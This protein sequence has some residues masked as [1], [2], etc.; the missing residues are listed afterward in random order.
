MLSLP[1]QNKMMKEEI[2]SICHDLQQI[3]LQK[4]LTKD[5]RALDTLLQKVVDFNVKG[6]AKGEIKGPA[7]PPGTDKRIPM[8]LG[9]P[10]PGQPRPMGQPG[11][12]GQPHQMH[13]GRQVADSCCDLHNI[14]IQHHL[15]LQEERDL[16]MLLQKVAEFCAKPQVPP[17]VNNGHPGPTAEQ[18][19]NVQERL[20]MLLHSRTCPCPMDTCRTTSNCAAVK[21]L[22]QHLATC[23]NE[24]HCQVQHCSSSRY[25]L[26]HYCECKDM[27]CDVC[28]PIRK[29]YP[30]LTRA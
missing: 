24:H 18:R 2:V 21:M 12:T 29:H 16:D 8:H 22:W 13:P 17:P 23:Q 4:L 1:N 7:N 10:Q 5:E 27:C 14:D 20:L 6:P 30:V 26:K 19:R 3:N 9:Q 11:Q 28:A 25:I 15:L